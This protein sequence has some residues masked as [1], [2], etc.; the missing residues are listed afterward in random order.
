M[1]KKAALYIRVSTDAQA[2]E[3][4][5]IGAQQEKL[6]AFCRIKDIKAYELYTDGGFSGSN[7]TRPGIKRLIEDS[8][9]DKISHVIVYKLDRLSRSQKDTLYLIED[10]FLPNGIDFVSINENIDTASPYGR[11]MIGILSA[12]AQLERENIF[13]RT[14]MGML[15][16]VK[17][18]L[19]MG[20]GKPP[21]G[22]DYDGES[23]TLM[24]NADAIKVK[25]AYELY[26]KGYS[27]GAIAM[28][29]NLKYDRLVTQILARKSNTGCIVYKGAEYAGMHQP[30]VSEETYAL[31]MKKMR[32]RSAVRT[33]SG[34]HLLSGLC[35]CGE[36]GARMRYQKW[37]KAGYKLRCYSSE[38]SKPYMV[39]DASCNNERPFAQEIED[40][41]VADLFKISADLSE[42]DTET[43]GSIADPVTLLNAKISALTDKLGRLYNLYSEGGSEI[44]LKTIAE[45]ERELCAAK[46]Q[47]ENEKSNGLMA[48]DREKILRRVCDI[49]KSW[50]Y[51]TAMEKQA[52]AR[53]CIERI[54]I[55]NGK[56]DIYYVFDK[57]RARE[58][59][60]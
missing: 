22:Y 36:C 52:I 30:I 21:F 41:V 49:G 45:N 39:R 43:G 53:D 19:W 27:P 14:R 55:T 2:E 48:A 31:A 11:A 35:Y 46:K 5:S 1:L 9:A 6:E 34:V 17:R 29:L 57:W 44:L 26:I 38:K 32:E 50:E 33:D 13:M 15:E 56:L 42:S 10:V 37:G 59:I 23:G 18:G 60:A 12:F 47:L 51:M 7:L 3:G 28:M 8:A 58:K 20:G 16:R 24:P 40:I 54:V 4:Y 25:R